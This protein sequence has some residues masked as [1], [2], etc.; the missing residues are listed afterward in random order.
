MYNMTIS[1]DFTPHIKSEID[2]DKYYEYVIHLEGN[3]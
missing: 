3:L 2:F 1:I